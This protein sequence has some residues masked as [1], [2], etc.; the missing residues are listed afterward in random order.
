MN[1]RRTKFLTSEVISKWS[2]GHKITV[3]YKSEGGML[4]DFSSVRLI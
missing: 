4:G 3:S 1:Q 2:Q